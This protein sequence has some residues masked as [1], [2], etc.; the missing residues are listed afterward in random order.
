MDP[1]FLPDPLRRALDEAAVPVEEV[2][3]LRVA[4]ALLTEFPTLE[5]S[6]VLEMV[7]EVARAVGPELQTLLEQRRRDRRFVD[8]HVSGSS[9]TD[10]IGARDEDGRVVVGPSDVPPTPRAVRIPSYL[11]GPQVTL[12]GPPDTAKMSINA[13]N[14]LH[15]RLPGE[16]TIV[17]DL[18]ERSGHV[19]RWGADSEDS[20]TPISADLRRATINLAGCYDGTLRYQDPST[21]KRYSLTDTGRSKPVK[22]PQNKT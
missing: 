16:S 10:V 21:G 6:Y 1:S 2:A 12:F 18:V 19:P 4:P 13:M 11:R 15:R 14:A 9:K 5:N 17:A 7:V 8:A 20:K 22:R 3:G